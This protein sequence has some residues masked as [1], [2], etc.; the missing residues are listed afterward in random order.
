MD[1]KPWV[2]AGVLRRD[3]T[4]RGSV[5]KSIDDAWQMAASARAAYVRED[6]ESAGKMLRGAVTKATDA[7]LH[8][9]GY[10]LKQKGGLALSRH[11]AEGVFGIHLVGEMFA[12]V[13]GLDHVIE[14][15]DRVKATRL[16]VEASAEYIA[17]VDDLLET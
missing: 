3:T 6:H 12:R 15:L 9:H 14:P 1:W 10:A 13:E 11:I 8:H 16:G 7:L 5:G 2:A 17:L 4:Q